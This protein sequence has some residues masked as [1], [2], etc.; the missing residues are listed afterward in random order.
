MHPPHVLSLVR[1]HGRDTLSFFKLRADVTHLVATSGRALIGYAVAGGV[2]LV[3]GDP[4]GPTDEVGILL[5]EARVFARQRG[6]RLGILGAS[7]EMRPLAEAAGL[8]C[9][10]VG[11]EAIVDTAEFSMR[12]S[13]MR[14]LRKPALRL[15][16]EGWTVDFR[17]LGELSES[18][19]CALEDLARRALDGAPERSFAW[20][21][22]GLRGD[23]QRDSVVVVGRDPAGVPHGLL[24]LV[25]SFGGRAAWSVSLMRR[26]RAAANGLMDVLVVRAIEA[27]QAEGIEEISLNFAAFSRWLREPIGRLERAGGRFVRLGSRFIQMETL[28]RFNQKFR[29]RWEPRYLAYEGRLGFARAGYA[30]LRLEG[31]RPR[32]LR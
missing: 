2:M 9:M 1:A 15:E 4:V 22:D 24:H 28:L 14:K 26:D 8:R 16:R 30:A 29:P 10:Y 31:Q 27:A 5:A 7:A 12:G 25:P 20:A 17:R 21:M 18:E 3:G 6:L 23:H 32:Q 11:D 19:V 13:S